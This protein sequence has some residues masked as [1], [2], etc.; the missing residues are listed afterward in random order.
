[1]ESHKRRWVRGVTRSAPMS[2]RRWDLSSIASVEA[3]CCESPNFSL[4][5]SVEQS[6][7][8][9]GTQNRESDFAGPAWIAAS[10]K[11]R[12]RKQPAIRITGF[13]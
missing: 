9:G 10:R 13:S 6:V 5:P 7:S 11:T 8:A 12:A 4:S 2:K 3:P 1:M